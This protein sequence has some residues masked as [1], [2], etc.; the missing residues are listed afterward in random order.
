MFVVNVTE[1]DE[2]IEIAYIPDE[3]HDEVNL[4]LQLLFDNR[5]R[6]LWI[7]LRGYWG[8]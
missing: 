8:E 4:F 6:E 2:G 5:E 7:D 1:N 3:K